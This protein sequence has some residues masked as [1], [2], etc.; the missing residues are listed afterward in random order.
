MQNTSFQFLRKR[1]VFTL[2]Q[3]IVMSPYTIVLCKIDLCSCKK[4]AQK[5]A[6]TVGKDSGGAYIVCID[7]KT[8]V[9]K[10]EACEIAFFENVCFSCP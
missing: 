4:A 1:N 3:S 8:T 10:L 5:L 7:R 9:C 2:L 6:K